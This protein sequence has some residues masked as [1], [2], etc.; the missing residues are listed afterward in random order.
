M[1]RRSGLSKSTVEGPERRRRE[2][3]RDAQPAAEINRMFK[4]SDE[5][6]GGRARCGSQLCR[7]TALPLQPVPA[8]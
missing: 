4:D 5:N 7:I 3:V 2:S 8:A 1:A 6:C